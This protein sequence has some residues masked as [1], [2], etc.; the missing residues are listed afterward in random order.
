[1]QILNDRKLAHRLKEDA[2]SE[3]EQFY[4]LM[5]LLVVTILP[6]SSWLIGQLGITVNN[7]DLASDIALFV[8]TIAG[9]IWTFNTNASGDNKNFVTR[10][11]CLG[12]PISIQAIVLGTL[13]VVIIVVMEE[14]FSAVLIEDESTIVDLILI[15]VFLSFFFFRLNGAIKIAC[16]NSASQ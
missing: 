12:L 7:W 2:V 5:I 14:L 9:S 15:M 8:F 16:N 1:M 11:I 3:R 4:Y 13:L 10:Y 6:S